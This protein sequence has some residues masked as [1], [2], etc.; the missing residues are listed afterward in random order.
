[1]REPQMRARRRHS[2]IVLSTLIAL[3]MMAQQA[4]LADTGAP[5]ADRQ[6]PSAT[7]SRQ[8]L[9]MLQRACAQEWS[10]RKMAGQT[11][12]LIWVEF[13]ETCRKQF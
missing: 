2:P 13:F 9:R 12:G 8:Q 4:S 6:T 11:R 5:A 3:A 1:M 10:R 7:P